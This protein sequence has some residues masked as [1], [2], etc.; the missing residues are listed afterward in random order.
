MTFLLLWLWEIIVIAK[1]KTILS[2]NL[3][4]SFD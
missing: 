1:G 3:N 2:Y 4:N